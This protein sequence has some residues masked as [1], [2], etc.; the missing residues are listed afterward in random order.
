M[1]LQVQIQREMQREA[2]IDK[3]IER[4]LKI[5][6]K[7]PGNKKYKTIPSKKGADAVLIFERL[8]IVKY[9][10]FLCDENNEFLE[11]CIEN[12]SLVTLVFLKNKNPHDARSITYGDIRST[13]PRKNC[14]HT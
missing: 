8:D 9:S 5:F 13:L 6:L 10:M 3:T 2:K 1:S 12:P 14:K 4:L 7:Q 11:E